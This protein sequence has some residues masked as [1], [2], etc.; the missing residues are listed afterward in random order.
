MTR[1]S[2]QRTAS[3]CRACEERTP[4][5]A[6]STSTP[7][8]ISTSGKR[9]PRLR[10]MAL[11]AAHEKKQSDCDQNHRPEKV[12][13]EGAEQPEVVEQKI[14]AERDQDHADPDSTLRASARRRDCPR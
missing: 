8:A 14:S 13:A 2:G 4:M 7:I 3:R 5:L 11:P 12:P 1:S 6:S 9:R 10:I